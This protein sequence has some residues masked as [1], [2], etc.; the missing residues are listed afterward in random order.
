M[1]GGIAALRLIH[2]GYEEMRVSCSTYIG[3]P[4]VESSLCDSVK[5][6]LVPSRNEIDES[7]EHAGHLDRDLL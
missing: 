2:F 5:R 7:R 4:F 1:D 6:R 3:S